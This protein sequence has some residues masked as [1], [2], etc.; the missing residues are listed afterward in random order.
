MIAIK[1]SNADIDYN[2]KILP[3][4]PYD[5]PIIV[6]DH[7]ANRGTDNYDWEENN[8]REAH[9]VTKRETKVVSK[10]PR[11]AIRSVL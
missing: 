6:V 3:N 10:N 8:Q 5:L 11:F 1:L 9:E 7:L 2:K 4:V